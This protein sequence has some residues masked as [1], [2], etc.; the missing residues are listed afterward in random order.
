MVLVGLANGTLDA[1]GQRLGSVGSDVIFQPPESSLILGA[2]QAVMPVR[3]ADLIAGVPEVTRV[4]PVLN[5]HVSELK[6]SSESLNLW[7][8]DYPSFTLMSGGLD[9]VRGHPPEA[10]GDV[11]VDSLLAEARGFQTGDQ[12]SMLNRI[13]RVAGISRPG[14]GGRIYARIQDIQDAIGTP[15]RASF[16][17][18]KG[19]DPRRAGD[20]TRSLQ[21]RFPGYKVTAIAQVLQ[22]PAG[23]RRWPFP[24]QEG[25]HGD[26]R[27]VL[28]FVVVLLAMYTAVIERTREIGILRAMGATRSWVVGLVLGESLLLSLV[29][30]ILG[31]GLA[32]AGR[33]LLLDLFPAEEIQLSAGWFLAAA[34]LSIAGDF[35]AR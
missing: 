27:V 4:T 26:R 18:V 30:A 13:F 6:G 17:L 3:L 1:I 20:L 8:I 15:G 10:A 14:S 29:G 23:E 7:A 25:P 24:V 28:S 32:F 33:A 5:W 21:E 34:A 9:M 19:S 31:L 11:V 35:W 2:S 16:F 12:V 22:G